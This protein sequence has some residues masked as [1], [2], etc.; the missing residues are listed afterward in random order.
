MKMMQGPMSPFSPF[1]ILNCPWDEALS[2]TKTRL[3]Q[4]G[5]RILQTFDLNT[6]RHAFADYPCPH[7]GTSGCDCQL[8]ILLIYG[9]TN[10]PA[11]LILQ[12]NDGRTWF[13]FENSSL[14]QVDPILCSC[15]EQALQRK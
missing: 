13:S 14:H 4:A 9:M 1:Y 15:I 12:G 3:S 7:H 10:E 2:W 5:L 8:V 6:A 11:T